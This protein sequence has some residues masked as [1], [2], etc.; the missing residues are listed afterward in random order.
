MDEKES[1]KVFLVRNFILVMIVVGAIE[2]LLMLLLNNVVYPSIHDLYFENIGW[3]ISL[4]ML[5]VFYL[6]MLIFIELIL[7]AIEQALPT[8]AGDGVRYLI[9]RIDDLSYRI[10]PDGIQGAS[11]RGLNE[12]QEIIFVILVVCSAILIVVPY[13]LGAFAYASLTNR[14][15]VKIQKHRE[16]MQ[17]EY[18]R[19]RNLMLSD[20]AHDLRTPMTTVSGYAKALADGM[21]KDEEKKQEYLESIQKKSKRMNDLINL[22]FEYVK[23]DSEGF[24]L[25]KK[26]VDL[27]ELARENAAMIYSDME[28][29]GMI[30]DIDIPET[31]IPVE[32]DSLQISRVITN[33]LNNAIRHNRANTRVKLSLLEEDGDVKIYVADSGE[34]IAQEVAEHLFEP[35]AVSDESRS[36]KGGSGLGLSI[37]KKV[38]EMHGWTLRLTHHV[39]EGYTKAFVIT[40]RDAL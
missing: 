40:I 8:V 18:D 19:K 23:L 10:L 21:I 7:V 31:C 1:L 13:I 20:I 3:D 33:L 15:V 6:L 17:K 2:H 37:A 34:A 36:T 35:F 22:L 4:N 32:A 26:R 12:G 16:E 25:D 27:A 9:E 29:N 30:F 24:T 28:D 11:F 38:V 14:E 39:E 5:Q